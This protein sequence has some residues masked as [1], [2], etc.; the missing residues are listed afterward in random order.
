MNPNCLQPPSWAPTLDLYARLGQ[1]LVSS[2]HERLGEIFL[3][4][5]CSKVGAE[6]SQQSQKPRAR[7]R[8]GPQEVTSR[9][10]F[11]NP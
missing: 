1:R 3:I 7:G 5:Q 8:E 11:L 9:A 2:S 10:A 4:H 6:A